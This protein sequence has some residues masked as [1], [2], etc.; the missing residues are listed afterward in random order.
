M[1]NRIDL[2]KVK[3]FCV[4]DK[5]YLEPTFVALN[6]YFEY[7]SHEVTLYVFNVNDYDLEKFKIF[8]NLKIE[9]L[10]LVELPQNKSYEYY[11]DTINYISAKVRIF[12]LIKNEYDYALCFDTD[13]FFTGN[14]EDIFNEIEDNYELYGVEE[15]WVDYIW[16]KIDFRTK[17]YLN[18]GFLI[19]KLNYSE[20]L[21]NEYLKFLNLKNGTQFPEQDFLN[22]FFKKRTTIN[23]KYNY[24]INNFDLIDDIRFVHFC[25]VLKPFSI[26]VDEIFIRLN[27][28]KEYLA[29]FNKYYSYINNLNI[30]EN[31]KKQ[32]EKVK[33]QMNIMKYIQKRIE[34]ESKI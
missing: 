31:F 8:K 22:W 7:N 6:S 12:D 13:A 16:K 9:K 3:F 20:N 21:F 25:S 15:H 27:R 33:K 1:Y 28:Y 32:C 23:T 26:H 29:M 19:V 10:E 5:N 18:V 17:P 34:N 24:L 4:S 30:S 11:K 14:V 2:E